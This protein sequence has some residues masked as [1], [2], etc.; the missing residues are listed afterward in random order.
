MINDELEIGID[1][2]KS[3]D[4]KIG[5]SR[6]TD[7]YGYE[8]EKLVIKVPKRENGVIDSVDRALSEIGDYKEASELVASLVEA[9]GSR[10]DLVVN[11]TAVIHDSEDGK[12]VSY[13]RVQR[14]Y[15]DAKP[16]VELGVKIL[17]LPR[18]SILD[19]RSIFTTN[20]QLYKERGAFL[21]LVG[22]TTSKRSKLSKVVKHLLPIFYSE[23]I[24][25]DKDNTPRI[26]DLGSLNNIK[27][28]SLATKI[29]CALQVLGSEISLA[30][31]NLRLATSRNSQEFH[32]SGT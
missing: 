20:L 31:L 32:T 8:K 26:I 29:R 23:N 18:Q 9:N 16:L 6:N 10:S 21:D 11:Q 27:T 2:F 28:E 30:I 15:K 4:R 22:S 14:W 7:V 13:S 3:P 1:V 25:I 17:D 19:L 12:G 24:V 5:Q